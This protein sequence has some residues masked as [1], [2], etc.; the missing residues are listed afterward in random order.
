MARYNA[1][2]SLD[3]SFGNSGKLVLHF[4]F[5]DVGA[6]VAVQPNGRILFGGLAV[7]RQVNI[8]PAL[9]R[10]G[11]S[12]ALDTTFGDG[13]RVL[14]SPSFGSAYALTVGMLL[15]P[16]GKTILASDTDDLD[17]VVLV[18]YEG[19][20]PIQPDMR[21]GSLPP[22]TK[23]NAIYNLDGTG[24]TVGAS[25]PKG[26]AKTVFLGVE[27]DGATADTFHITGTAADGDFGI[28]YFS[29]AND[30]TGLVTS[31]SF[32]TPS[33][34]PGKMFTLKASVKVLTGVAKQKKAFSVQAESD[35]QP[36]CKDT[37]V[38]NAASTR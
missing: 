4:N 14:T 29:G 2:G 5:F 22:L 21:I 12:G 31:G 18:R 6:S 23:G 9:A 10:L 32:Q 3:N 38:I 17:K 35:T 13:G 7:D 1:N 28:R 36:E 33:I 37:A 34:A 30:V 11:L 16:D 8:Y 24:Q 15:Q 27:N 19:G 25:G 20:D 26:T